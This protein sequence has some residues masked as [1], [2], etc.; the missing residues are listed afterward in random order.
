MLHKPQIRLYVTQYLINFT[1][2][3]QT[4]LCAVQKR[5]R[6]NQQIDISLCRSKASKGQSADRHIF[7]PVPSEDLNFLSSVRLYLQLFLRGLMSYL[8]YLCLFTYS[9]VHH[10]L[11]CVF[12]F[13]SSCVPYV[14][15][16][17]ILS[18]FDCPFIYICYIVIYLTN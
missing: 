12:I 17:S 9:G 5:A 1:V 2:F 6:G 7:V 10:I 13:Y 18:I 8:R 11:C 3:K 4:H 16:F 15:S 14:A